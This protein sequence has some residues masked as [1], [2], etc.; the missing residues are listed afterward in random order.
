MSSLSALLAQA[1]ADSAHKAA[2]RQAR[3]EWEMGANMG[4][5][6]DLAAQPE[7]LGAAGSTGLSPVVHMPKAIRSLVLSYF[8]VLLMGSLFLPFFSTKLAS[9]VLS[10]TDFP[11]L[12]IPKHLCNNR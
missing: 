5:S 12:H 9:S 7:V 1:A 4:A 6:F 2:P 10:K 11:Y 3:R 8:S